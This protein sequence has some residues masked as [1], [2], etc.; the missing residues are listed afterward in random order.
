MNKKTAKVIFFRN[1]PWKKVV[2]AVDL[3]PRK[4]DITETQHNTVDYVVN[5]KRLCQWYFEFHTQL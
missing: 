3:K 2:T 4:S 1:L 5:M